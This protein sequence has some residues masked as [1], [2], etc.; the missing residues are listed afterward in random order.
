MAINN[1]INPFNGEPCSIKTGCLYDMKSFEEVKAAYKSIASYVL[2]GSE[3]ARRAAWNLATHGLIV[4]V[5]AG[6]NGR[7]AAV[8]W[9]FPNN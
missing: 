6:G 4:R 8:I 2:F 1:G 5:D 9:D 3:T 7:L